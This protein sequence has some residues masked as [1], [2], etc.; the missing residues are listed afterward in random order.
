MWRIVP[1]PAIHLQRPVRVIWIAQRQAFYFM[2]EAIDATDGR[3]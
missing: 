1:D 3:M 2:K